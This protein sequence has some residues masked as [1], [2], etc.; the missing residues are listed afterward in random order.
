MG[1]PDNPGYRGTIKKQSRAQIRRFGA[2]WAVAQAQS[3]DISMQ[4]PGRGSQS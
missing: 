3:S 4:I 2:D 1:W